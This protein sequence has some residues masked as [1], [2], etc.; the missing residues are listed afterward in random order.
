MKFILETRD[1]FLQY[2]IAFQQLSTARIATSEDY[3]LYNL[4]RNKD[5]T[6]GFTP[7]VNPRKLT[8]EAGTP[9]PYRSCHRAKRALFYNIKNRKYQKDW[10]IR[11]GAINGSTIPL[12]LKY[13][14]IV[15]EEM[16]D[17]IAQSE[18]VTK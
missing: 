12:C 13:G 9:D 2:R 1:Q 15:T 6:R 11:Y 10:Y 17:C 4:L 14:D 18:G 16:W 7:I 8:A 5:A 3:V